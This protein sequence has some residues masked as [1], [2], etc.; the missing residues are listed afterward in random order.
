MKAN[1]GALGGEE[2]TFP[3]EKGTDGLCSSQQDQPCLGA[4]PSL[5]VLE[6]S[7]TKLH[8]CCVPNCVAS[9]A[10]E[11]QILFQPLVTLLKLLTPLLPEA[12]PI[13]MNMKLYHEGQNL[14][15]LTNQHNKLPK[16][17]IL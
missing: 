4:C 16:P 7:G 6:L 3:C 12:N 15:L 5:A 11:Q 1:P 14:K 2:H 9:N 13:F 17:Q 8:N 10:K